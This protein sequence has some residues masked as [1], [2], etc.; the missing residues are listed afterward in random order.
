MIR[1]VSA[2]RNV[3]GSAA[4]WANAPRR[5]A[6]ENRELRAVC[7]KP[8]LCL[9]VR[10]LSH[11]KFGGVHSGFESAIIRFNAVIFRRKRT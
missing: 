4:R 5:Q 2:R 1:S 8:A 9:R 3:C 10:A 7:R 11:E 6:S